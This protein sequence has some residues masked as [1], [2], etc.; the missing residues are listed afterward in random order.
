MISG[1]SEA[2]EGTAV[3]YAWGQSHFVSEVEADAVG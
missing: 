3:G 1:K 2:R